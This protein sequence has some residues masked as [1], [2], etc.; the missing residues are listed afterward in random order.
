MPRKTVPK[1]RAGG[2][3]TEAKYRTFIVNILRS[4]S[5]KW[6]PKWQVKNDGREQ[7]INPKTG[8]MKFGNTCQ[9]CNEWFFMDDLEIDHI[10]NCKRD[11]DISDTDSFFNTIGNMIK[12]MFCE[13]DNLRRLCKK[14]HLSKTAT[15]RR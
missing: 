9:E 10:D 8:K 4:G 7:R 13:A 5:Q 11:L 14:C 6:P 12:A 3:W 1:T 15:E 2:Q